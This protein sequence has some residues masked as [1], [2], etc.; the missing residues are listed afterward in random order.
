MTT[1]MIPY[2]LCNT[3]KRVYLLVLRRSSSGCDFPGLVVF[4]LTNAV[5]KIGE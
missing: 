5:G 2:A 4:S 3:K 1:V